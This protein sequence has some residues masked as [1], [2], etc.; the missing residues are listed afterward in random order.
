MGD[1][2]QSNRSSSLR[3]PEIIGGKNTEELISLS[4]NVFLKYY[5]SAS[6]DEY[7]GRRQSQHT[8]EKSIHG[9]QWHAA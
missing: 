3:N 8:L 7:R 6:T 1:H 9:M 4:K 5:I 2:V